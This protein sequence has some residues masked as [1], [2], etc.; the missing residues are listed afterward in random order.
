MLGDIITQD[1]LV[2]IL[3]VIV[4]QLGLAIYC[5]VKIVRE[6]VEDRKSVV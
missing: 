4:L 3:P 6:G 2:M 1:L 5:I